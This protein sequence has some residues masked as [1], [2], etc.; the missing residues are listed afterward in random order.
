[1]QS[2]VQ[3]YHLTSKTI[4]LLDRPGGSECYEEGNCLTIFHQNDCSS[5][6]VVFFCA[7]CSAWEKDQALFTM[8]MAITHDLPPLKD[9]LCTEFREATAKVSTIAVLKLFRYKFLEPE[10]VVLVK[11]C[12]TIWGSFP[13]LGSFAVQFGGHLRACTDTPSVEF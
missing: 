7:L 11:F 8:H 12:G 13:V 5:N 1:M 10:N 6:D 4:C 9:D 2:Y 3:G